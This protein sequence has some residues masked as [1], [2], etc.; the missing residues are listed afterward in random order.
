[1]LVCDGSCSNGQCPVPVE[2]E[3]PPLDWV[4]VGGETGPGARPTHPAWV[5][6]IRDD[7][8]DAGVPFFFKQWG[9]W[10][11]QDYAG[12]LKITG[13][14]PNREIIQHAVEGPGPGIERG[15]VN[16]RRVGKKAA[17]HRLD[18]REWREVPGS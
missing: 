12:C 4:I 2:V 9:E 5:R 8:Q 17:G 1:M 11:P 16:M 6:A 10:A 7:C 13:L 15:P 14:H 3:T 18:G